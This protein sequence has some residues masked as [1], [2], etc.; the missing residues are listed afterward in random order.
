MGGTAIYGS[1]TNGHDA[2]E[3]LE[4]RKDLEAA[5]EVLTD[6][7]HDLERLARVGERETRELRAEV[8]FLR[9]EQAALRGELTAARSE[10]LG[11][12]KTLSAQL[13]SISNLLTTR[14]A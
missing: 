13:A 5:I 2:D 6:R 3:E 14:A 7:I 1:V 11:S 10:Q 9:A 8:S 12:F 4:E